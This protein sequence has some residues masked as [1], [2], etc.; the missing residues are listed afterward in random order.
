MLWKTRLLTSQLGTIS[1]VLVGVQS[2]PCVSLFVFHYL[3]R[4]KVA[5]QGLNIQIIHSYMVMLLWL[6]NYL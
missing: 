6:N 4:I 3:I 2:A 1:C 5:V